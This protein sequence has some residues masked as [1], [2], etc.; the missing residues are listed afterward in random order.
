MRFLSN[1]L[2][3]YEEGYWNIFIIVVKMRW[4]VEQMKVYVNIDRITD[5][6][7]EDKNILQSLIENNNL[8]SELQKSKPT[9]YLVSGYKGVGKTS[10]IKALKKEIIEK[11]KNTFFVHINVGKYSNFP[12]F[13]RALI[14][15]LYR[16]INNSDI[17]TSIQEKNPN[18]MDELNLI[19]DRTFNSIELKQNSSHLVEKVINNGFKIDLNQFITRLLISGVGVSAIITY[20]KNGDIYTYLFLLILCGGLLFN[21]E[22]KKIQKQNKMIELNRVTIY[23][24]EV[25]E[26]QL[27]RIIE[28]LNKVECR[29][30]FVVDELDKIEKEEEINNLIG[31]MKPLM[32]LGYANFILISGQRLFYKYQLADTI[33]DAIISS[34]F[35]KVI[36]IPLASVE[37]IENYFNDLINIADNASLNKELVDAYLNSRILLSH[38]ILR[39]FINLIRQD[40]K[41]DNNGKC[42]ININEEKKSIYLTDS[43]LIQVIEK[44]EKD[45]IF[46]K[47]YEDGIKDLL[48]SHLYIGAKRIKKLKPLDFEI[49]DIIESDDLKQ[50]DYTINYLNS[51][52][53]TINQLLESMV[54][55]DLLDK[56]VVNE[57]AEMYKYKWKESV[58]IEEQNNITGNLEEFIFVETLIRQMIDVMFKMNLIYARNLSTKSTYSFTECLAILDDNQVLNI[59]VFRE[60]WELQGIRDTI[61]QGKKFSENQKKQLVYFDKNVT[62][63]KYLIFEEF[64]YFLLQKNNRNISRE[65][66]GF[67]F[68]MDKIVIESKLRKKP[69][70]QWIRRAIMNNIL[71]F[72]A[73][74]GSYEQLII[75]V[76]CQNTTDKELIKLKEK[77]IEMDLTDNITVKIINKLDIEEI[78]SLTNKVFE[79]TL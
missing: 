18:L 56:F 49:S 43:K 61:I 27:I 12:T 31:E 40:I 72:E 65:V 45:Y 79:F 9:T 64:I 30:N 10:Y 44:V 63:L 37:T 68:V 41:F 62:K 17:K 47:D 3:Q 71:R 13:L 11:D 22:R 70:Y 5:A 67:D 48:I 7:I 19:Y 1:R 23:D 36:H 26:Y 33:D 34:L 42:Y 4:G 15:E 2:K 32:L 46:E 60:L 77:I 69:N 25:A 53:E 28:E 21:F 58:A 39:K 29:I 50:P 55:A 20:I 75:I 6:P 73:S 8:V 59:N 51:I 14:R 78:S 57:D 54:E 16:E 38:K 66:D 76:F 35:A 24:D 52:S 74:Q